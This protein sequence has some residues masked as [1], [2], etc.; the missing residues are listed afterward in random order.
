VTPQNLVFW[1]VCDASSART[2]IFTCQQ[3]YMRI[4]ELFGKALYGGDT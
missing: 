3:A 2:T 4:R 1:R